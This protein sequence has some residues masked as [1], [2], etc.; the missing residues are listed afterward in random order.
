MSIE[1]QGVA[2]IAVHVGQH[3][4]MLVIQLGYQRHGDI[5]L[6]AGV[7]WHQLLNN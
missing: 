7:V 4:G 3:S 5:G 2:L 1:P 6:C